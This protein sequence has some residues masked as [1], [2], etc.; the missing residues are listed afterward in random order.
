LFIEDPL[1]VM[2]TNGVSGNGPRHGVEE[3]LRSRFTGAGLPGLAAGRKYSR[4]VATGHDLDFLAS[5]SS[6][7]SRWIRFL[8]SLSD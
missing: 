1:R 5:Q 3:C 2:P 6:A 8:R 7:P 4:S